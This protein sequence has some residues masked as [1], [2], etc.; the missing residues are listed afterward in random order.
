MRNPVDERFDAV[1][2]AKQQARVAER[3]A[4]GRV[5]EGAA[6]LAA[7]PNHSF[8]ENQVDEF[9]QGFACKSQRHVQTN[10]PRLAKGNHEAQ[11]LPRSTPDVKHSRDTSGTRCCAKKAGKQRGCR[12]I[13]L[14]RINVMMEKTKGEQI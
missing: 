7:R 8:V 11:R 13:G 6:Q 14:T 9:V 12:S 3:L 2:V 4:V 5:F 1:D 10:E